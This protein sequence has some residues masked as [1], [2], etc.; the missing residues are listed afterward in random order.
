VRFR[1]GVM[2]RWAG[3]LDNVLHI[4]FSEQRTDDDV[5]KQ[6]EGWL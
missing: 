4:D 2:E 3:G 1:V 6:L 5:A